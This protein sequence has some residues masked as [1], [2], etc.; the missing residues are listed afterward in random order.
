MVVGWGVSF[1][2]TVCIVAPTGTIGSSSR[3]IVGHKNYTCSPT[4]KKR[5]FCKWTLLLRVWVLASNEESDMVRN[6]SMRG[7]GH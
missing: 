2:H 7:V 6:S 4:N 3:V 1:F 5:L